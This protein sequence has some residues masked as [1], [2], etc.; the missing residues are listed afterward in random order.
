MGEWDSDLN[1]VVDPKIEMNPVLLGVCNSVQDKF[2]GKEFSILA[3]G[4]MTRNGLY[5]S[6]DYVI[7]KQEVSVGGI[8][9][10]PLNTYQAEGYNVV[11]H[12]HHNLGTFFSQT[13][14][15]YIN[16]HFPYSILYTKGAFTLATFSFHTGD[17]TLLFKTTDI[18]LT[19]SDMDVSGI[20]NIKL[21]EVPKPKP[22]KPD[23]VIREVVG[24]TQSLDCFQCD[25]QGSKN[26]LQCYEE[27]DVKVCLMGPTLHCIDCGYCKIQAEV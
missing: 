13:D 11:I 16:S 24:G 1:I 2:P 12:S 7:P 5:V 22:P 4:V 20:Q 6:D 23:K 14:I 21:K 9:Y 19:T 17:T 25:Y 27:V 15:N 3:K 8:D 18:I 10:G 26:C